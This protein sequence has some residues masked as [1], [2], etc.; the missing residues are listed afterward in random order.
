[1]YFLAP[2]LEVKRG[3]LSKGL[4]VLGLSTMVALLAAV[5]IVL[6]YAHYFIYDPQ[7]TP[8]QLYHN[9]WSVARDNIYDQSRLKDWDQWEHK[10][11][12]LI[13]TEDDALKYAS[14]MVEH[15]NESY[16]KLLTASIVERDRERADGHYIGVG[17]ELAARGSQLTLK[18]VVP[19]GPAELAGLKDG[20]DFVSID[21]KDV[22]TWSIAMLSDALKGEEGQ[23]VT[24]VMRRG[25]SEFSVTIARGKVPQSVVKTLEVAP[26]T[27]LQPSKQTKNR[28]PVTGL[29]VIESTAGGVGPVA[30]ATGRVGYIR[31]ETFD[32]WSVH[33][34]VQEAMEKL[35]NADAL[36]VDLRDNPGG[37]IHEAVRTAAL[38]MD[39]GNVTRLH[40]RMPEG[41][42]MLT[43]V[44]ITRSQILLKANYGLLHGLPV[45]M[46]H[47]PPNLLKGRPVV[48]LVNGNSASAAEMFSAALIDNG[49]ATA[50][51]TTTFGKGIGQTYLPIGNGHKLRITHLRAFTPAGTFLGDAGQTVSNGIKPAI[52]LEKS[53]WGAYGSVT[54]NQFQEAV[55][56]LEKRLNAKP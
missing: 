31:I 30:P 33:S 18:R 9:T 23:A 24:L 2:R 38:F 19:G 5:T 13:K 47:R 7:V 53:G 51:G 35:A 42:Y 36:V 4:T 14:E 40:L 3:L 44:N 41:G 11:D 55:R 48:L 28:P 15:L 56:F 49:I 52:R 27:E 54:D 20:D 32:Q 26:V 29:K 22:S 37:F 6:S 10:Y 25:A 34:Q 39:E 50:I 16:T 46:L 1:M 12:H 8:V 21:G 43:D 45:P 17:V